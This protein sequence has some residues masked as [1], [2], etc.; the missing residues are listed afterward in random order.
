MKRIFKK[1]LC[2]HS[3]VLCEDGIGFVD[4]MIRVRTLPISVF[5]FLA[6]KMKLD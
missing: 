2:K 1:R 3:T 6:E 5:L 4:P